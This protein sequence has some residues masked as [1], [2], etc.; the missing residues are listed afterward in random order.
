MAL[1]VALQLYSVRD[2]ASADLAD[3]LAKVKAM[4]Y[5]GVEL[6]GTYGMTA[7]EVKKILDEVKKVISYIRVNVN[8]DCTA[9]EVNGIV[10]SI[11]KLMLDAL[12][13]M[14][15]HERYISGKGDIK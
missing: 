1:P 4:G 3:T 13:A 9:D 14:P 2:A 15:K 7:V 5:D 6:A 11:K 10:N 8:R 12:E